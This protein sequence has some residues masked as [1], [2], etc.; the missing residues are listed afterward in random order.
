M[1]VQRTEKSKTWIKAAKII[2]WMAIA[3]F[4]IFMASSSFPNDS[5][6]Q[7]ILEVLFAVPLLPAGIIM[8][9]ILYGPSH[10]MV[11]PAIIVMLTLIIWFFGVLLVLV[12]FERHRGRP[13]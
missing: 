1:P 7:R 4:V 12:L 3:E 10:N 9:Q 5:L 13:N 2:L 11:V 8:D 6:A